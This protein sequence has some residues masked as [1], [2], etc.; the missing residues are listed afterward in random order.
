MH[1]PTEPEPTAQ[2]MSA[3][4][5]INNRFDDVL[6][7]MGVDRGVMGPAHHRLTAQ[8]IDLH[9]NIPILIEALTKTRFTLETQLLFWNKASAASGTETARDMA[10]LCRVTIQVIDAATTFN[11]NA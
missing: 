1:P 10:E 6:K 9:S 2:A 5:V 3:A 4:I 8:L 7:H 11:D